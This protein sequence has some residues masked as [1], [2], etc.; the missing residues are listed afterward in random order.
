M[1]KLIICLMLFCCP[2]IS[3]CQSLEE[4]ETAAEKGDA[5]AQAILGSLYIR[6]NVVEKNYE[7]GAR[8]LKK[9]AAQGHV[10]AQSDLAVCYE[11]GLGVTKNYTEALHW[12]KKAA[13]IFHHAVLA[14]CR[15]VECP[16]FLQNT[17]DFPQ[18]PGEVRNMIEHHIR[19]YGIKAVIGIRNIL[20]IDDPVFDAAFFPQGFF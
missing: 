9:A 6:G 11:Q 10:D 13:D 7:I 4:Y 14:I 19:D 18:S 2:S 20:D 12:F 17:P 16:V 15:A 8:W 3:Y 5:N 1:K